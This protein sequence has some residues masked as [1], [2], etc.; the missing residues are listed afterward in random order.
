MGFTIYFESTGRISPAHADRIEA[1]SRQL[2]EGYTWLSCE[3]PVGFQYDP[4]SGDL[5]GFSKP[6]FFPDPDDAASAAAEGL[7]DG[8]VNELLDVLC[9]LSQMFKF[10]WSFS[11]DEDPG[12]IG[13]IRRGKCDPEL[14][15]LFSAFGDLVGNMQQFGSTAG[16]ARRDEVRN[17]DESDDDPGPM[18]LKFKPK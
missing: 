12:P 3:P 6:N 7:P 15:S 11:H 13:F 2:C 10:D 1:M 17:D 9:E 14:R 8:T 16:P 5:A 4:V 18:I